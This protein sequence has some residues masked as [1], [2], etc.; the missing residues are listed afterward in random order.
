MGRPATRRLH[1]GM[2]HFNREIWVRRKITYPGYEHMACDFSNRDRAFQRWAGKK[3]QTTQS[4]IPG[5]EAMPWIGPSIIRRSPPPLSN[6][7][8]R[9][10]AGAPYSRLSNRASMQCPSPAA[11]TPTAPSNSEIEANAHRSVMLK[12]SRAVDSLTTCSMIRACATGNPPG[13]LRSS[14]SIALLSEYGSAL[15]R[16]PRRLLRRSDAYDP[17]TAVPSV[18]PS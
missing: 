8:S 3:S 7:S 4:S 1:V 5:G 9:V 14:T 17:R 12:R 11:F 6:S 2:R 15:V 18:C 13:A 10:R 16:I